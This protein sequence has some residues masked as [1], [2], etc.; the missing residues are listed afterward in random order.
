MILSKVAL[1]GVAPSKHPSYIELQ[2]QYY[3]LTFR[4]VIK[5]GQG[6]NTSYM[7]VTDGRTWQ[8]YS[9]NIL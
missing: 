6:V 2:K 1:I 8:K 7:D 5:D 3:V 4:V 9:L